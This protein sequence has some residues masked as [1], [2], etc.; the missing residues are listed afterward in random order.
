MVQRDLRPSGVLENKSKPNETAN[1]HYS[2]DPQVRPGI[3]NTLPLGTSSFTMQRPS[4][5]PNPTP[6]IEIGSNSST[7]VGKDLT[8]GI[9]DSTEEG[10]QIIYPS[11]Q[12]GRTDWTY[13]HQVGTALTSVHNAG[14]ISANRSIIPMR[15]CDSLSSSATTILPSTTRFL[16]RNGHGLIPSDSQQRTTQDP[17]PCVEY[18]V[19]S[20]GP[21]SGGVEVTI[22]GTDFPHTLPLSVYFS[23]KLA[24]IVS[25]KHLADSQSINVE[26]RADSKDSGDH[27]MFSSRR[28]ISW[29]CRRADCGKIP[30]IS[31]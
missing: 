20:K 8:Q 18:V 1:Q 2:N 6:F 30:R 16:N 9:V 12:C 17:S 28:N 11:Q 27:T 7:G 3:I 19:P 31:T 10:L 14:M 24:L 21:M 22:V 29:N 26:R 13:P 25:W 15:P 23:T 5:V 4:N